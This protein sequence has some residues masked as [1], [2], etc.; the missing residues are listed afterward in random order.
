MFVRMALVVTLTAAGIPSG[1]VAAQSRVSTV[2]GLAYTSDLK[3]LPSMKVQVRN[4][5][6]ATV[7]ATTVTGPAG[8]YSFENLQPANYM[9]ELV[10][11]D[12]RIVGMSSPFNLDP[13]V[14]VTVSV[15]SVGQGA[16]AS[17]KGAGLSLFGMGPTA[18]LAVLGAAGVAGVTAIVSTRQ[19][20]S[21]SR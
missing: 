5:Q 4:L 12:G 21:P 15:V 11:A 7:V 6:T 13:G 3:P 2:K 18:T 16:V 19:D 20:A 9:I 17:S 1:L 8:E 10:S 14:M